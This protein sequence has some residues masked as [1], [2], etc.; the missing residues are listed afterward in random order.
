[1]EKSF[2]ELWEHRRTRVLLG[3]EI[4]YLSELDNVA[5]LICHAAGHG[6]QRLRWLLDIYKL[7]NHMDV[8]FTDL[9]RYMKEQNVEVLCLKLYW[10][11]I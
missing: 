5:Y 10:C 8:S 3:Q 4:P 7:K 6:Y 9:Y 11:Y 1:M 2:D